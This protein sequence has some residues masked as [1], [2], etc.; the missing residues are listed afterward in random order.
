MRAALLVLAGILAV[1]T[2][3]ATAQCYSG[4]QDPKIY[5]LG[6][7]SYPGLEPG[8]QG[9]TIYVSFRH[10]PR[11]WNHVTAHETNT[12]YFTA[13]MFRGM[14]SVHPQT[15]ALDAELCTSW[16]VSEDGLEILF[17]LRRGIRWSDGVEFTA[18]DVLFTYN[19][20]LLNEDIECSA[21]DGLRLPDGTFPVMTAPDPYTIRVQLSMVFRPLVDAFGFLIMPRHILAETVHKL[22]PMVPRGNYNEV[23]GLDTE[24]SELVGLGPFLVESFAADQ[25]VT[26]IRNPYYYAYDQNGTQLP[27]V[28]RYVVLIVESQDVQLLKF[29]NGEIDSTDIRATDIPILAPRAEANGFELRVGGTSYGTGWISFNQDYGL[30]EGDPRKDQLR[31]LFRDLRFRRAVAHAIDRQT[32]IDSFLYGMGTPQWSPVSIPSPFYAG[33]DCYGCP[34]SEADAVIYEYDLTKASALLDEIGL[35]DT[36][37]DGVREFADG[38]PV[39]FCLA[40]GEGHS[41]NEELCVLL[42]EDLA[43]IGVKVAFEP[44]DFNTLV[45]R[46]LAG[47]LTQAVV[48]ALTGGDEPNGSANV[49]RTTGGLHFW[50]YSAADDPYPYEQRIDELFDLGI[51]TFDNDLAFA[52]YKELQILFATED[53]GLIFSVRGQDSYATYKRVRNR[54]IGG[55]G[56]SVPHDGRWEL[57]W[58]EDT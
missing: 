19:D 52:Y 38:Q 1:V 24:P 42:V 15:L 56:Y 10:N 37:G 22:N 3:S 6:S 5:D 31:G 16:E 9:G 2:V 11:K 32:L 47:T 50:H 58:V 28:D 41:L 35:F 36:N 4:L 46:M 17:H 44:V 18:T 53:L 48:L 43:Q 25:R 8:V 40:T 12:T 26:M 13:Q 21:G 34:I 27:Y 7:V 55:S 57:Y 33:R 51:S 20:L 49:L 29:V 23:W 54:Q 45:T 30:G 39:E 14:I